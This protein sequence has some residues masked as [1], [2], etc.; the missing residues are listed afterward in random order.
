[1]G[2]ILQTKDLTKKF[3]D[4]TANDKINLTIE[5]GEI[6]AIVGENGAGKSTLMNMLYWQFKPTSGDIYLRG[7]K[8]EFNSPRDAIQNGIGMVHQHFMLVPSF[9]V[10][11]NILLGTELSDDCIKFI[12]DAKKEQDACKELID[13]YGFDLDV[14]EIVENLS[15]GQQQ[16]IEILKML[17]RNV[18]ILILDEPTS[19][20]TP[21][22]VDEL[23]LQLKE[24]NAQGKTI[25]VI[26]HKLREVMQV[27]DSVTVMK[28]GQ[29]I[30]NV[31]TSQTNES[32]LAQMMVGRKV[33][34]TVQNDY[35]G[36]D[37]Q[38]KMYTVKNLTTINTYGNVVV[39]H[40][41]FEIDKGEIYG[42]AGVEGNGQSELVKLLSG[43]MEATKGSVFFQ[44][45]DVS[46][47]WADELRR[48][49]IAIIPE[50][51]YAQGLCVDM[52]LSANSIAGSTASNVFKSR[53]TFNNK[54]IRQHCQELID[55]YEIHISEF[56]GNVS[57]LSG[58]NAQKLIIAR[59]MQRHPDL[60]IASQPTRGVDI[61]AIE[62]IHQQILDF[63]NRGGAVL[64]ISSELSEIM[65]LSDRIGVMYKGRIIGEV[66][67]QETT[68]TEIG[69]LMAG[70]IPQEAK[71]HEE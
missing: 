39:D 11:E 14:N 43:M 10:Y 69:L 22:E 44:G 33:L 5:E 47:F 24:L 18:D 70:A 53:G 19:V 3:G 25:I 35:R 48:L 51:R 66:N 54:L 59:E 62:F 61:G 55:R 9:K 26:T 13:K 36:Q 65:S 6:K 7:K 20:L 17:Y 42:I 37:S 34:L 63:R 21:Q 31:C 68:E 67:P 64:L 56:D 28:K 30:G 60:L 71:A 49:G 16:K 1:M 32:E 2:I 45:K 4:F 23:L 40:V 58:G 50:D 52:S 29:I 27:S 41:G 8:V 38:E 15:V 46:N 12:I 57:Q